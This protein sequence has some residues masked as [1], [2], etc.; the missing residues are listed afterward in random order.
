[1]FW[2]N[3]VWISAW[4]FKNCLNAMLST[5]MGP[6]SCT[7]RIVESSW[8]YAFFGNDEK[9]R[10]N[11]KWYWNYT[12]LLIRILQ[13]IMIFFVKA[14]LTVQFY[15]LSL[16]TFVWWS[17]FKNTFF[18]KLKTWLDLFSYASLLL[19]LKIVRS[20]CTNLVFATQGVSNF[21]WKAILSAIMRSLH[22]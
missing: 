20:Y 12:C 2:S 19:T 15:Q 8:G 7:I 17:N 21:Y 5:R 14:I 18:D 16:R 4:P 6:R 11:N 13:I 1:M 22:P 9:E 3:K 10:G